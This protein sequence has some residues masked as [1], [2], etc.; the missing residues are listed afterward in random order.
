MTATLKTTIIQEPSSA[1]ANMTLD[2]SGGVVFG[3]GVI[4]GSLNRVTAIATTS[5][6]SVDFTG[7]NGVPTWAKRV[8][9]VFNAISTNGTSD[10]IVQ[11]GTA[12]AFETTGYSASNLSAASTTVGTAYTNGFG[13][14]ASPV[15]ANSYNGILTLI[16]LSDSSYMWA[17]NGMFTTGNAT[18]NFCAGGKVLS[19]PLTRIRLT[20]SGGA[21]TFDNGSINMLYEG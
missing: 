15:A 4:Q 6:T 5:G 9:I 13:L 19:G 12:S 2:T 17:A 1:I 7:S 18:T 11:L 3:G 10:I 20:T 14:L 21:N 8:T 16:N